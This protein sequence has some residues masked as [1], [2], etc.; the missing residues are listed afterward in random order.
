MD[1]EGNE[2]DVLQGLDLRRY[3]PRIMVIEVDSRSDRDEVERWVLPAGYCRSVTVANNAF[4]LLD[5][6]MDALLRAE[7]L[8]G[9]LLHTQHPLDEDGDRQI[10]FVLDFREAGSAGPGAAS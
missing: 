1:V 9:R 3:R 4:Y 6:R 10:P 8:E 5:A 2:A 7:R